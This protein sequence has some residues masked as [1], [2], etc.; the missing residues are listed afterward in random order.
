MRIEEK[1]AKTI[2]TILWAGGVAGVLDITSAFVLFGLRGISPAKILQGI[3]SGLLGARSYHGGA[4]TV[5][6]GGALH[7]VIAISAAAVYYAAS[8]R[9][10]F[11]TNRPIVA[12]LL[13]G[14][15]IYAFM[16]GVVL[17][18]S[19]IVPKRTISAG[20][21]II[22]VIILSCLVGLPIALIV[23]RSSQGE[24]ESFVTAD[25][26]AAMTR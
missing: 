5:M 26:R 20:D 21:L 19:A 22:G 11:L 13:Y 14:P 8:R 4:G 18:L 23:W 7:F 15:L 10:S 2:R 1:M 17:P 3:A 6:L 16:N 9:I 12:G 24:A 25:S